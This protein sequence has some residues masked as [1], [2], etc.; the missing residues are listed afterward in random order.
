MAFISR[1]AS[2]AFTLAVFISPAEAFWG[3]KPK[4]SD[5]DCVEKSS[6]GWCFINQ[7]GIEKG[8]ETASKQEV[9]I[10]S[11]E[12]QQLSTS[13]VEVDKSFDKGL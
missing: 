5:S 13:D 9:E 12:I 1:L 10:F 6:V 3:H 4:F 7:A 11:R 2:A 8:V